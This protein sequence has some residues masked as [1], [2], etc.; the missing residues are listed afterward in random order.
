M[1]FFSERRDV[2]VNC[3]LFGSRKGI[4]RL[5]NLHAQPV[6]EYPAPKKS[7]QDCASSAASIQRARVHRKSHDQ[8]ANRSKDKTRRL[9][10]MR[11][12]RKGLLGNYTGA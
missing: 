1:V 12:K 8:E 7:H 2:R 4:R 5:G 9:S 6:R 3:R 11:G 10:S